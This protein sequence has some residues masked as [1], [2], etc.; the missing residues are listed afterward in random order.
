MNSHA[1]PLP[2]H[3]DF[4]VHRH[5]ESHAA[6]QPF[7]LPPLLPLT[8]LFSRS[9]PL[10]RPSETRRVATISWCWSCGSKSLCVATCSAAQLRYRERFAQSGS[11]N[12]GMCRGSVEGKTCSRNTTF[13]QLQLANEAVRMRL[14]A[15]L[16]GDK[17]QT[18]QPFFSQI[19][20]LQHQKSP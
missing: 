19:W 2:V 12:G 20:A 17:Q 8:S 11:V 5:V 13:Q 7:P 15:P 6:V 16:R 4:F 10:P 3:L 14:R 18:F 1:S 9:R